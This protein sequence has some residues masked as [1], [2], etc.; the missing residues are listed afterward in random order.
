MH[1]ANLQPTPAGNVIDEVLI[2]CGNWARNYSWGHLPA[3]PTRELV[4]VSCMDSRQPLK[5]MLGLGPGDAHF[6]R[7]AGGLVTDDVLRSLLIS[8]HLKA[9]REIMIIQ[10]TEC[11]LLDLREAEL[12]SR[13]E[14]EY[15]VHSQ[16]PAHFGGFSSLE[17]SV[18]EQVARV[19]SH[20][21]IPH[22]LA[23]RGFIY[24]V[25][26]GQIREVR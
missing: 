21:W 20:P 8:V 12:R 10:H 17:G 26:T 9:T 22:D 18:R 4:V 13:L 2:N 15:G 3:E 19:R 5:A 11:G 14:K 25:N 24:D 7:N 1:A 16:G 6:I 23:V